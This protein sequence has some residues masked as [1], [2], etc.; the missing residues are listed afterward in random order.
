[1]RTGKQTRM[2]AEERQK[3]KEEKEIEREKFESEHM[4]KYILLYPLNDKLKN[5]LK[6][7]YLGKEIISEENEVI[8]NQSILSQNATI[9]KRSDDT[10]TKIGDVS[11]T[12]E[13]IKQ[14]SM[15]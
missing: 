4:G 3:L 9:E 12:E 10:I 7:E 1:M 2:T 5:N 6:N 14:K 13:D 15:K 11:H 8:P